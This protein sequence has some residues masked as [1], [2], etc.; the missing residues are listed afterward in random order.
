MKAVV[1]EDAEVDVESFEL[2]ISIKWP[3]S[4][5]LATSRGKDGIKFIQRDPPDV[6]LLDLALADGYGLDF[7]SQIRLFSEVPVIVVSGAADEITRAR[8]IEL[9]ADDYLTKPFSHTE[10][11]AS[12]EGVLKKAHVSEASAAMTV[13]RDGR[14]NID[15]A[16]GRVS[17]GGKEIEVSP[18]EWRLLAYFAHNAGKVL[19]LEAL[20]TNVWGLKYMAHSAIKMLIRRLRLKL[21]DNAKSPKIIVSHRG[22]GYSLELRPPK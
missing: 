2:C 11:L 17:V 6:V 16:A 1:I 15:I 12:I 7:L 21:G 10:L 4:S 18:T 22:R 20:A 3:N 19:P 9:G 14:L 13:I 8:G 5:I